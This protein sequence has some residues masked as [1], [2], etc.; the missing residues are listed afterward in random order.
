MTRT[1]PSRRFLAAAML[2]GVGLIG[3]LAVGMT[4]RRS[5]PELAAP[6]SNHATVSV[7]D[8]QNGPV[9]MGNGV[10]MGAALRHDTS[11]ALRGVFG[12]HRKMVS[13]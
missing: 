9:A 11:K 10:L 6:G 4:P 12:K 5:G 2:A 7:E 1:R 8:S 3:A 13:S